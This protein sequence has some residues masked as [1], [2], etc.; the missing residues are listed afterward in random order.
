MPAAGS[1]ACAV[2]L[3]AA[4]YT[5]LAFA[6]P[7]S[8]LLTTVAV[9]ATAILLNGAAFFVSPNEFK[10]SFPNL[11]AYYKTPIYLDS[12]DYFRDTTPST[13]RLRNRRVMK[14]STAWHDRA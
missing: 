13:A 8:A 10:G 7:R 14:I 2:A 1:I 4:G 11:E 5:I 12:H 9:A 6:R 3:L